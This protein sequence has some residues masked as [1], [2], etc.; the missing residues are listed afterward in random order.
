MREWGWGS[1][2]PKRLQDKIQEYSPSTHRVFHQVCESL[3]RPPLQLNIY[4]PLWLT[5]DHGYQ[6]RL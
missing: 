3:I 2:N 1:E 6:N 5:D 4:V